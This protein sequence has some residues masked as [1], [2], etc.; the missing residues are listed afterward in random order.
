MRYKE[1][2]VSDDVYSLLKIAKNLIYKY[3]VNTDECDN[4]IVKSCCHENCEPIINKIKEK[5]LKERV[6]K[7]IDYEN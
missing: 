1:I 2:E 3:N 4:C 7:V 6:I 5:M